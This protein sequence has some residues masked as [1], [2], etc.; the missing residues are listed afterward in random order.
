MT[1]YRSPTD[2]SVD[3]DVEEDQEDEGYDTVDKQV[4]VNKI[5][6]DV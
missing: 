4:K 2:L 6:L 3:K 5:N 1:H